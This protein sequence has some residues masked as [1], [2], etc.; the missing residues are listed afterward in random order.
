MYTV[1]FSTI[2]I[3]EGF[4]SPRMRTKHVFESLTQCL[5]EKNTGCATLNET[6]PDG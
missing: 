4:S 3:Y 1:L 6:E 5:N 2:A